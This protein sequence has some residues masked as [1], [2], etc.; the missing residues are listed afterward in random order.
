MAGAR[1]IH[2]VEQADAHPKRSL[3]AYIRL[4]NRRDGEGG[5]QALSDWP[6]TWA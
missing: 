4:Q 2:K 5:P 3:T 1:V 6:S